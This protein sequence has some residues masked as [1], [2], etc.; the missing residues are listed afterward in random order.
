MARAS[1]SPTSWYA[2]GRR[3][4]WALGSQYQTAARLTEGILDALSYSHRMGIVHR[5]IKPA[6]VMI[7]KHGEIKV[8]D[9]GIARAVADTSATMTQ[10]V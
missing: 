4:H 7:G 10:T 5:D 1:D 6:N 9:F 2:T 3:G 8:M